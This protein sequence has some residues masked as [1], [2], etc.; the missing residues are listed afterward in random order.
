MVGEAEVFE[1]DSGA[2][3]CSS[4]HQGEHPLGAPPVSVTLPRAPCPPT[5]QPT[6]RVDTRRLSV[7]TLPVSTLAGSGA[8]SNYAPVSCFLNPS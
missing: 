2:S 6:Y 5:H 7:E 4:K 8:Q 1:A 3:A